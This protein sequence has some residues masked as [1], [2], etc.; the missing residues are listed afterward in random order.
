MLLA[1]PVSQRPDG[2]QQS[3]CCEA[4]D[5]NCCVAATLEEEVQAGNVVRV[6]REGLSVAQ[7]VDLLCGD[8]LL[9][10]R[11][12]VGPSGIGPEE[13]VPSQLVGGVVV[14][15]GEAGQVPEEAST[16]IRV[17]RTLTHDVGAG[18]DDNGVLRTRRNRHRCRQIEVL[19][20][21]P[22]GQW[23][24]AGEKRVRVKVP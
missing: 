4:S 14:V 9:L 3:V 1:R 19:L 23:P 22:V 11:D 24:D 15:V 8:S 17:G 7:R 6:R 16:R 13:H 2:G 10:V 5:L 12:A 20:A 18:A 21:G